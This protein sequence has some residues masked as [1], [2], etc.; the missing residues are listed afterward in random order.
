VKDKAISQEEY[1]DAVKAN[2][3]AEAVVV[4][5]IGRSLVMRQRAS[6]G[7]TVITE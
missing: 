1:H 2:L 5:A 4:P 7:E 6:G 3:E